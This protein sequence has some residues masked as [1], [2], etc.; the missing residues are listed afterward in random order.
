MLAPSP[1]RCNG[2]SRDRACATPS[3]RPEENIQ[4]CIVFAPGTAQGEAETMLN[5][6]LGRYNV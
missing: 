1:H 4:K 5:V 3:Q 6:R 2:T